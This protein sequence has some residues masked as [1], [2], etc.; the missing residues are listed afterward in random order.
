MNDLKVIKI[1]NGDYIIGKIIENIF[2]DP[3]IL[4]MQDPFTLKE[5]LTKTGYSTLP[6]SFPTTDKIIE[7][8][9][10][11]IVVNPFNPDEKMIEFYNRMISNLVVPETN[12][13]IT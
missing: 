6:F 4:K 9:K 2:T 3:N 5:V 10:N 13:I 8:N 7:I 12:K 1:T 11:H